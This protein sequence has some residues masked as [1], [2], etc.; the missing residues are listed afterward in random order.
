MPNRPPRHNVPPRQRDTRHSPPRQTD[1]RGGA[2][3]T[4][5]AGGS[6]PEDFYAA[7]LPEHQRQA[8][9]AAFALSGLQHE[10][11]LVRVKLRELC[12]DPA[13]DQTSVLRALEILVRAVAAAGKL[14]PDDSAEVMARVTAELRGIV[15]LLAD[16]EGGAP[17]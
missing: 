1:T 8:F 9:A 14:R 10:I 17:E 11:A 4:F 2:A 7:A 3:R 13:A 12:A 15:Q 6:A 5:I 16:P